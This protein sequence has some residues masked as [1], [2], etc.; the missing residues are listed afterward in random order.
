MRKTL[1]ESR[2]R[3]HQLSARFVSGHYQYGNVRRHLLRSVDSLGRFVKIASF[4][5]VDV[6]EC[7]RIAV[8]QREPATLNLNHDAMT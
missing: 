5:V 7:L 6:H 4:R 1:K 8:H 2:S 3:T